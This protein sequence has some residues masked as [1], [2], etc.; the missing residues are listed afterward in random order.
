MNM[1]LEKRAVLALLGALARLDEALYC[2]EASLWHGKPMTYLQLK[3]HG[4][5]SKIL[6]QYRT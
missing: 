1:K 3:S 4:R 5:L 6:L 2:I